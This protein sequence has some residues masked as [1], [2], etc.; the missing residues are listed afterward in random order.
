MAEAIGCPRRTPMRTNSPHL[1]R[2]F[3]IALV[4]AGTTAYYFN[5]AVSGLSLSSVS[6]SIATPA[7]NP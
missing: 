5:L 4:P 1:R 6:Q 3:A 7:P 2:D